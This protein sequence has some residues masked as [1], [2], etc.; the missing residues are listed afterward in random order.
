LSPFLSQ[1][2]AHCHG[3]I[4][5][6]FEQALKINTFRAERLLPCISHNEETKAVQNA[7]GII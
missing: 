2:A 4:Y 1:A 6:R 7:D 3:K 5:K